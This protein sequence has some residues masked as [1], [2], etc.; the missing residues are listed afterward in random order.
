ME[1]LR[2]LRLANV[3]VH[4]KDEQHPT[5]VGF[6]ARTGLL[7][8]LT[9][10]SGPHGYEGSSQQ[11][12]SM[13]QTRGHGGCKDVLGDRRRRK[14]VQVSSKKW[15]T[16]DATWE[17]EANQVYRSQ[18]RNGTTGLSPLWKMWLLSDGSV[19]RHLE[20]VTEEKVE[21]DCFDM[22]AMAPDERGAEAKRGRKETLVDVDAIQT[23][24]L[25]RQ[26]FLRMQGKA[27]VYAASWWCSRTVDE[28]LKD[29]NEPIWTSLS[30]SRTELY[31]EVK[32]LYRGDNSDLQREFQE[33][34]PFWGRHYTFY[35]QGKPL[36]VI[37]E[38]FSPALEQYL[39]PSCTLEP[40]TTPDQD[41]E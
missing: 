9:T 19:T 36:T 17:A 26:V 28:Y 5:T 38:V 14:A 8:I 34:G 2:N 30:T 10:V 3:S 7:A 25:Q 31:R 20:L 33:P 13:R 4:E 37:Y 15:H 40:C 1:I 24:L 6:G 18:E 39:G 35:H 16:L 11:A 29:R 22:H 27:Y 23:P 41:V 32:R 12:R 21:V